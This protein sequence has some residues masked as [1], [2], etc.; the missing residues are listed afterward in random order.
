MNQNQAEV[1]QMSSAI[2]PSKCISLIDNFYQYFSGVILSTNMQINISG[3]TEILLNLIQMMLKMDDDEFEA[4]QGKQSFKSVEAHINYT[5]A[6]LISLNQSIKPFI[7]KVKK[8]HK[9]K[10]R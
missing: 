4:L 10:P 1:E 2:S 9:N 5:V 8:K 7:A 6:S 3:L